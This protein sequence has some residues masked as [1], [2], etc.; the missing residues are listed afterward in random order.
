MAR[1]KY[2]EKTVTRILEVSFKLFVE[3][4]Y[5]QTTIQDIVNELGNLSKG[6]IYH[7]F[8]NK[9]EIIDAVTTKLFFESGYYKNIINDC[10]HNGAAK[11]QQ[12]IFMSATNE[13]QLQLY[14]A[15]S[16][17]LSHN[18]KLLSKY[19]DGCI[20]TTIPMIRHLVDD[21]I[22]DGSIKTE[23]PAVV[24]EFFTIAV[25]IW[26]NPMIFPTE[27]STSCERILCVQN[28]FSALGLPAFDRK[29]LE[30]VRSVYK[31]DCLE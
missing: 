30:A 20:T 19:L 24:S 18:P 1:N 3:R 23:I 12:L 2:P 9:E 16:T 10:E 26:L 29:T 25:N 7:H 22:A 6:A 27:E 5:E 31:M 13:K 21:G 17:S 28:I 8:K 4:G 14:K 15:L 11:L